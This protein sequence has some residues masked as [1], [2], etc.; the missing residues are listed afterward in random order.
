[1]DPRRRTMACSHPDT[2]AAER[3]P[4]TIVV[5]FE[6]SRAKWLIGVCLPGS[7]K[8]SRYTIDAGDLGALTAVLA[9]ARRK[10]AARCPGAVVAIASCYEAGYDGF[11][12]HRWLREQGVHN[13]VV[14]PASIQVNRRARRAKTDRLD[15]EQLMRVLLAYR[16]GEPRVCSMVHVPSP[17]QEDAKRPVRERERL[18]TERGAHTNRIKALLYGQGI[19]EVF[20]RRADFVDRLVGMRTADGRPLPPKLV[21]EIRR[22]HERVCLLDR[23][24]AALEAD[25]AADEENALGAQEARIAQLEQLVGI[26]A[27]SARLLVREV[28]YRT[29][30]NRRQVGSYFGLTGT[31]TAD[32][33]GASRGSARAANARARTLAIEL[34]WLWVRHQPQSAL[35][36]WFVERVGTLKGRIRRISIVAVARKLMVALWRYLESGLVP[37][38]ARL[39]AA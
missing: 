35:A 2:P 39:R 30:D 34:A 24:V 3:E 6:L 5:A 18:I 19:G 11:W 36:R 32:R 20:P 25:C 14:D 7:D 8:L 12:L 13:E 15:L 27:I 4:S 16:R 1:M 9:E 33:A 22:E 38:G 28:F 31:P 21:T 29:F 17:E 10:V 37:Q 26:G 23:Q